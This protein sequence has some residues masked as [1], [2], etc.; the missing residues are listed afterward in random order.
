MVLSSSVLMVCECNE[1][2]VNA[3][4]NF[5]MIYMV[6]L[7]EYDIMYLWVGIEGSIKI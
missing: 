6:C 5:S 4:G 1:L 3:L 2:G 7:I